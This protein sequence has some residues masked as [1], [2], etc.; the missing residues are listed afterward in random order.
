MVT[1]ERFLGRGV[2]IAYLAGELGECSNAE[3]SIVSE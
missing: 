3:V 2:V 1:I